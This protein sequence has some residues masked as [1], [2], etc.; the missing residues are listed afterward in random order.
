MY[1]MQPYDDALTEILESGVEKSN[2]RTGVRTLSK[3][4]M[5][6]RYRLDTGRLPLVTKRKLWPKP[7]WAELLWNIEGSTLN[8]RLNE[9]GCKF[10]GQWEDSE[11]AAA[12]GFLADAFGPVYGYNARS[13][14]GD[15][16]DGSNNLNG[17]DQLAYIMERI[18]KDTS[19]RRIM[20][21]L[22]NPAE[23]NNMRLPPC[24]V[25]F[26][27]LIDDERRMTGLMYQRSCDFPVGVPANIQFYSTLIMMI[28]QQTNCTPYEFVHFTADSHI[29]WDQIDGVK[30]YLSRPEVDSPEFTLHKADDI[31]SYQLSDFEIIGYEPLGKI[32]FPIAV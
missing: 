2:V 21:S 27:L 6:K 19:C 1:L 20:W 22:W 7:V 14:G 5:M 29:Y 26:Q 12:R 16:G 18:N 13:F 4:G 9:L 24:H 31:Y 10:W 23:L 28:A 25:L 3:F 15:Y 30:E 17:F 32:D 11:W 8:S